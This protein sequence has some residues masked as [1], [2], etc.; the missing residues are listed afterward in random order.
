ADGIRGN[1]SCYPEV[2]KFMGVNADEEQPVPFDISD[3]K[4]MKAYFELVHHP[5]ED[6]GVDFWWIDWQQGK[7]SSIKG[8][9][10]LYFLNHL[11]Y[12][13]LGRD[14]SKRPF[15]FSRW[16]GLGGH[17]YPIG[18]S[19]DTVVSWESL[20]YQPFFTS[21]AANVGYGWWSHDIGGH[22][23]GIDDSELYARWVQYGVF[24]PINRLHTSSGIFNRREPW[25]HTHEAFTT[26]KKFLNLRHELVPYIYTMSWR[27]AQT[28]LPFIT[29]LYYDYP[30]EG[31]AYDYKDEYFY[32]SELLVAPYVTP[33]S[34]VLNK[35]FK[36]VWLPEGEWFDFA[37][38]E[39]YKGDNIYAMYGGLEQ[40]PVFAK[41]GAIIPM[42]ALEKSNQMDNPEHLNVLVFGKA[43][44]KF[45]MYEDDGI[46]TGYEA[47]QFATTTFEVASSSGEMVVNIHPANGDLSVLPAQ[48]TYT[49]K[50]RGVCCDPQI[51]ATVNGE[52]VSVETNYDVMTSTLSITLPAMALTNEV[53]IRITAAHLF[54]YKMDLNERI[55][56][57]VQNAEITMDEKQQ[58]QW[59]AYGILNENISMAERMMRLLAMPV[60]EEVRRAVLALLT[61][62]MM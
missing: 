56:E 31:R 8:L 30:H 34:K 62:A 21:T 3:P 49:V 45:E 48:R 11:H 47:G 20:S 58:F 39:P 29:P 9:D 46:S 32:G 28:G 2:A 57:L 59:W 55:I 35:T 42:A 15:T 16:P 18:F 41:A 52:A 10:P 23:Q 61:K 7:N 60:D 22:F 37:T 40:I 4:F 12:L 44:N 13:D 43:A 1:E 24:S 50:F 25:R 53:E 14:G 6:E 27:N 26:A 38:G 5:M 36:E 51:V 33:R 17:R 54:D 19:G